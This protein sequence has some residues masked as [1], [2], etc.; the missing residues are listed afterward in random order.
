MWKW[1][2]VFYKNDRAA[3]VIEYALIASVVSIAGVTAWISMGS[4][5]QTMFGSI[6]NDLINS[7]NVSGG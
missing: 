1:F 7:V 3:T 2:E 5:L 6:S 4:S